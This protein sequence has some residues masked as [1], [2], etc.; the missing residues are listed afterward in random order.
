MTN[1]LSPTILSADADKYHTSICLKEERIRFLKYPRLL[2][3]PKQNVL[4]FNGE[5]KRRERFPELIERKLKVA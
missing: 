3:F 5:L 2:I 1:D 4:N